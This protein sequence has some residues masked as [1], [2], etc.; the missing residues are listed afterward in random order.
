M[1]LNLTFD[2]QNELMAALAQLD[3][4]EIPAP[5]KAIRVPYR[6]GG[7]RRALVKNMRALQT[8]LA[9]WQEIT[10]AIFKENFP[11]VPDG[12]AVQQKDRPV[13]FARYQAAIMASSQQGDEIELMPFTAKMLY[14]E[15]EFPAAVLALLEKHDLIE[16]DAQKPPRL[17]EVK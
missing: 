15:N 13:E 6:L 14:E 11:D 3:M 12:A 5:D 16:D 10:K 7:E 8:S 9:G 4:H 2:Q 1:K 17:R